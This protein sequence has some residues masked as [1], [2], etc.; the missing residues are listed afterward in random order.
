M[1]FVTAI[2]YIVLVLFGGLLV[3]AAFNAKRLIEW[4]NRKMTALADA[5][6]HLREGLEEEQHIL[7]CESAPP[8]LAAPPQPAKEKPAPKDIRAA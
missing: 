5:V 8:V 1:T 4:E 7:Q 6:Q 3:A 2:P